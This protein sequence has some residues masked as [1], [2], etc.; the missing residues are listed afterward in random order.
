MHGKNKI[1]S[2]GSSVEDKKKNASC[3]G[4]WERQ[5]EHLMFEHLTVFEESLMSFWI[6]EFSFYL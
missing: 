2:F 3:I 1:S 6:D 4:G 5:F